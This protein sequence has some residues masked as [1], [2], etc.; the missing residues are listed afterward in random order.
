MSNENCNTPQHPVQIENH[1]IPA[2]VAVFL[3]GIGLL[4]QG[5]AIAGI[6][7]IITEFILG[8]FLL[9]AIIAISIESI[10]VLWLLLLFPI[11]RIL[12]IIDVAKFSRH[13]KEIIKSGV[14]TL[15][16]LC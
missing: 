15:L 12:C 6:L 2:I 3:G 1:A 11:V 9:L 4:V 14:S 7:W 10:N 8:G 16:L 5:R 13:K